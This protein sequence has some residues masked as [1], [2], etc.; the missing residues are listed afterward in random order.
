MAELGVSAVLTA[1]YVCL[2]VGGR[3]AHPVT[4]RARHRNHTVFMGLANL[5]LAGI[6]QMFAAMASNKC[7]LGAPAFD[8]SNGAL[9]E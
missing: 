4:S 2:G 5:R 3:V 8:S 6:C 7:N 1:V 9:F